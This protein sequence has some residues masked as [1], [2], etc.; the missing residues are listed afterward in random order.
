[1]HNEGGRICVVLQRSFAVS[2]NNKRQ[3]QPQKVVVQQSFAVSE[4]CESE[5]EGCR[6]L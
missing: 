1:M 3:T 4:T 5:S 2:E 6:L